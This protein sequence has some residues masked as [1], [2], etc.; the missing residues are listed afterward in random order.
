MK[1]KILNILLLPLIILPAI[2]CF[3]FPTS[4][5][6]QLSDSLLLSKIDFVCED[7]DYGSKDSTIF[8]KINNVESDS[9]GEIKG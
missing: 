6:K 2:V 4:C 1:K 3:C 9:Q 7:E 5:V 8:P